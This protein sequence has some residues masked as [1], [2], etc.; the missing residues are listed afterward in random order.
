MVRRGRLRSG[1]EEGDKEEEAVE[2]CEGGECSGYSLAICLL[3]RRME[4][5][6]IWHFRSPGGV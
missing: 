1:V 4:G 5:A 3:K 6:A 2:S